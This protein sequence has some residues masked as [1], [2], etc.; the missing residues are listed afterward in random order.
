M[1]EGCLDASHISGRRQHRYVARLDRAA[2]F[3]CSTRACSSCYLYAYA[4]LTHSFVR[5]ILHLLFYFYLAWAV[6]ADR[7]MALAHCVV[8]T[9]TARYALPSRFTKHHNSAAPA[10][11]QRAR[12]SRL[13]AGAA[14]TLFS[15]PGGMRQPELPETDMPDAPSLWHGPWRVWQRG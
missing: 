2:T 9:C 1:V 12:T 6:G 8:N 5:T 14:T 13:A 10:Y 4:H 3:A 15:S 11:I 7:R